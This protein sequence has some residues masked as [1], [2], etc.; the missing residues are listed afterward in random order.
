MIANT[1]KTN[2]KKCLMALGIVAIGL[3]GANAMTGD[4]SGAARSGKP[5]QNYSDSEMGDMLDAIGR[6]YPVSYSGLSGR[7]YTGYDGDNATEM[8]DAIDRDAP[9][10]S[11]GYAAAT[12]NPLVRIDGDNDLELIAAIDRADRAGYG[13]ARVIVAAP[14]YTPAAEY[15]QAPIVAAPEADGSLAK[16]SSVEENG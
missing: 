9:V 10:V 13:Q 16:T 4:V 1:L 2:V 14:A 3:S 12:V 6:D 5:Y 7:N 11:A 15:V 8:L